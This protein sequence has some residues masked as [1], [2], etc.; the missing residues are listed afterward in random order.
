LTICIAAAC[1]DRDEKYVVVATDRML[2]ARP[3]NIEFEADYAKVIELTDNCIV[4]TSGS[5]IAFTPLL[6][7]VTIE[8]RREST[9]DIDK[10]VE[11]IR[12]SYL[13]IRNKR[14]EE[15]VLFPIGLTL[16][17]YYRNQQG[18][19]QQVISVALQNMARYDYELWILIAGV[20]DKGPHISRMENPG[21]TLNYDS[22][23]YCAIGSGEPH[24]ITTFIARG[25]G[26][27]ATLER[28]L[29]T[30]FEAKKRSERAP[31]VGDQTDMYL[32][33]KDATRHLPE[34]AIE[35]LNQIFQKRVESEER[36]FLEAED[37][38]SKANLRKFLPQSPNR[39]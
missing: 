12:R 27:K 10:I 23:G 19:N 30:A 9:K 32:I 6:R 14:I 1:E 8:I 35:E 13:K 26:S 36:V 38:I 39:T 22:I 25:Y 7:D 16:Q 11:L 17:D 34:E 28:G 4:T 31:G 20:D 24:A 37:I 21:R 18:L 15:E 29:A 33:S 3:M 2:T 5:A